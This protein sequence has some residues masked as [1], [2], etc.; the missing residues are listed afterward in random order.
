MPMLCLKKPLNLKLSLVL[1]FTLKS[2]LF[3]NIGIIFLNITPVYD[4]TNLMMI[5]CTRSW[6]FEP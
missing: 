4:T 2:E 5:G 3:E 1:G 6:I